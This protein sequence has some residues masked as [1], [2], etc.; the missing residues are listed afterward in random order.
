MTGPQLGRYRNK[1]PPAQP[2]IIAPLGAFYR[3]QILPLSK[4]GDTTFFLVWIYARRRGERFRDAR[5]F[6][7]LSNRA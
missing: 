6:L 7:V 3:D 5:L 4:R 1:L 2:A